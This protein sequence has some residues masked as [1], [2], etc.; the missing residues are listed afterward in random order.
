LNPTLALTAGDAEHLPY[1]DR[2]FDRV[3]CNGTAHHFLD[4]DSAFRELYRVLV[5]GGTLVLYEPIATPVTSF[6]RRVFLRDDRYESP[7]DLARK[8]AFT[9]SYLMDLLVEAG[10]TGIS[11]SRHDFL[12]YPLSGNY[13]ASPLCRS[14]SLMRALCRLEGALTT[15]ASLGPLLEAVAW[16]VLVVAAKAVEARE[17]KSEEAGVGR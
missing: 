17:G 5:P 7:A 11:T 3:I 13:L 6:L 15:R 12:A 14:R 4:Q 9:P 1:K 10:F 16:R 8:E 2:S